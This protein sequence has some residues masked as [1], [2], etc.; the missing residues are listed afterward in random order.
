MSPLL[1]GA[2]P[3]NF[4]LSREMGIKTFVITGSAVSLI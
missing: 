4:S 2:K 3:L 1:C